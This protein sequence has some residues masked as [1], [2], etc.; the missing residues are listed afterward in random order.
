MVLSVFAGDGMG[1]SEFDEAYEDDPSGFE[2]EEREL[3]ERILSVTIRALDPQPAVRV[4]ASA[5]IREA[6]RVMLERQIGA[7]LVERAGR[8]VGIFTE[9]DVLRRVAQPQL[10]QGRPVAEAMTADPETLRL[11]DGIAF[12][13]NRMILRG[14]RHVPVLD[15]EGNAVAVVSQREVVAYIV[16]L[17]PTRVLNIP[18]EPTLE[19]RSADGG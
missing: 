1:Q 16:S 15:S 17:L 8:V 19:A 18:P 13:L 2:R 9:R 12:A 7:V 6:I 10:D 5:P 11:D 14:F 4:P 3:G